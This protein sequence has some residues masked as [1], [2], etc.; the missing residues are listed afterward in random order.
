[1]RRHLNDSLRL[2]ARPLRRWILGLGGGLALSADPACSETPLEAPPGDY[3]RQ[4]GKGCG[5]L[6]SECADEET[7]WACEDRRWERVDCIQACKDHGGLV[8]CI[9]G[10]SVPE[11]AHCQCESGMSACEPD[12][13][14][15]VS[16]DVIAICDPDLL[17]FG[18]ESCTSVCAAMEPPQLER[19][20]VDNRCDCTLIGTP[21]APESPARC[22]AFALARCVDEVWDLEDCPCSPGTCNPWGPE[23]ATCEC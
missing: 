6:P 16:D 1:M 17:T 14:R 3:E 10:S 4:P 15:C 12:Q 7:L 23:G 13:T 8:G 18:E 22:F 11:G 21:C 5:N 9:S 2:Y 20:C 19:G